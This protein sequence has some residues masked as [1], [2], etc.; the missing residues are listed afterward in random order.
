M[1]EVVLFTG[2]KKSGVYAIGPELTSTSAH[3]ICDNPDF[4]EV[5]IDGNCISDKQSFLEA[6]ARALD[7]PATFGENW[8]AFYDYLI[9]LS[10]LGK[11]NG[12]AITFKNAE[13]FRSVDPHAFAIACDLFR[14]AS[15]FW[16]KQRRP[17]IVLV[18]MP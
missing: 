13:K 7:F 16:E 11:A 18:E 12:Y 5:T 4:K 14:D 17:M 15:V 2:Q 1:A 10:W 8:D 9:D 3:R 6:A